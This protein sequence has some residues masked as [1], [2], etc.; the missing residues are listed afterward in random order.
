M[1]SPRLPSRHTWRYAL[2]GVL[3][4]SIFLAVSIFL[5]SGGR[6]EGWPS[7]LFPWAFGLIPVLLGG[8]FAVAGYQRGKLA[9]L[10]EHLEEEIARQTQ[11]LRR[12]NVALAREN[13]QRRRLEATISAAKKEWESIFDTVSD[14][15]VVVDGRGRVQRCNRSAVRAL[16][17]SFETILGASWRGLLYGDAP[18]DDDL[19][20]TGGEQVVFPA[21]EGRYDVQ[22]Y[23]L[24]EKTVYVLRDITRQYAIESEVRRQKRYF[25]QLVENSP[26]AVVIL[27][28]AANV[29]RC[30]PAFERLYGYTEAE[31]VGQNIDSLLTDT[32]MRREAVLHSRRALSGETVHA[33]GQRIR[34]DGSTVDVEIFSVPIIVDGEMAGALGLYHDITALV[35]ARRAAEEADRAK[36]EF[37]ANMSHEIRTPMNGIMGMIELALD[38]DLTEEQRDYLNTVRESAVALLNLLNDILDVSKIEAGQLDLEVIDFDLRTTVEGAVQKLSAKAAAKGLEMA[39]LVHPGVPSAVRGDPGRLRQV[40]LNLVGNAIKFTQEGEVVVRAWLQEETPDEV[41][42]RFS[43]SDTG[44]GIPAHRQEAIFE[45]FVQADGSATRR[46]G[47]TGLGLAIS[48]QLVALM[49]GEIGVESEEGRGSTFWFTAR[50]RR[51]AA[52][53]RPASESLPP[54]DLQEV[55]VLGVDDNPTNRTI[56]ARMLSGFGCRPHVVGSGEEA[57][58]AMRQAHRNGDPFALLLLDMQMPGMDGEQVLE[59]IKSDPVLHAVPVLILTSVGRRGDAARLQKK[60]AAGYLLKPVR[61]QQLSDAMRTVLAVE[62][63]PAEQGEKE[64]PGLVTRHTLSEQK[65]RTLRLL[66]AEDNPIEQK[67]ALLLLS[68][69]GY[70][71]D[72]VHTGREAVEAVRKGRYNLILMDIHMPEM[73]GLEAARRIRA[74][75]DGQHTPILGMLA[76][77]AQ[78]DWER[79]LEAGM[80]DYVSKPLSLPNLLEKLER[81][82]AWQ[83]RNGSSALLDK[84]ETRALSL[85]VDMHAALHRFGNDKG[86]FRDMLGEFLTH[87]NAELPKLSNALEERK[88][89]ILARYARNI[90]GVA[91]NFSALG[92][93]ESLQRLEMAANAGNLAACVERM[94]EVA[95]AYQQL[96]AFYRRL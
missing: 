77:A 75:E 72:I 48:R 88:I 28:E 55:H 87:L 64:Q 2:F 37:L 35:E 60:G 92:L 44:I 93:M 32:R 39:C 74:L 91:E 23:P 16:G 18:P 61:R 71:V 63:C 90:K 15:I 96:Q 69:A 57:L 11:E 34:K 52:A 40:L 45:R 31:A 53:A 24:G 66:L 83:Q 5:T 36:S 62:R 80:D 86:F 9:L 58:A 26:V 85:P 25:E 13:E 29:Q 56:L 47:G 54:V 84:A 14:L 22:V 7:V 12:K 49:G 79:C 27:D 17:G 41:V 46:Y 33:V 82:V 8:V 3:V 89:A 94:G 67:Q 78:E 51:Q 38:T 68:K 19:L 21:L 42:V 4:G 20:R 95:R 65:R 50:F 1:A 6:E 81:W 59:A 70:P 30:N 10:A 43:V 76:S 73:D